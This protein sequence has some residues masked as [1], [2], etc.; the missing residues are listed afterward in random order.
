METRLSMTAATYSKFDAGDQVRLVAFK[1]GEDGRYDPSTLNDIWV[2][3]D[4]FYEVLQRWRDN[5]LAEWASLP[6]SDD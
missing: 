3:N 1:L 5:F 4:R 2:A 6:K